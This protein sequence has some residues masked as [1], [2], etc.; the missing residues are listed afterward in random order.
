MI[1]HLSF[2]I[3][4]LHFVERTSMARYFCAIMTVDKLLVYAA[5][6]DVSDTPFCHIM[7]MLIMCCHGEIM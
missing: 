1:S 2:H 6:V 4:P 3:N 5:Q 7:R